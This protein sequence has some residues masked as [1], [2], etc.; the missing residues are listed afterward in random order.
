MH[1]LQRLIG[2]KC[3]SRKDA[4]R[5]QATT[6]KAGFETAIGTFARLRLLTQNTGAS[7]SL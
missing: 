4:G 6:T 5:N 7:I 3:V 1:A 2:G